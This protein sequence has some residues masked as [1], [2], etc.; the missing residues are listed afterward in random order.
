MA[1]SVLLWAAGSLTLWITSAFLACSLGVI[2]AAGS[3]YRFT[4]VV[5]SAAINVT[6][7]VPTSLLVVAIGMLCLRVPAIP[8]LPEI[9]PGTSQ[10]FQFCAWGITTA[11]ALGSSG[12]IAVIYLTAWNSVGSRLMDQARVLGLPIRVQASVIGREAA[13]LVV[14]ALGPRLVHH[15]HNTA[16]AALFPV[17]ELFGGVVETA[18]ET[19]QV[20]EAVAV[21]ALVYI[22]MSQAVWVGSRALEARLRPPRAR[23]ADRAALAEVRA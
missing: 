23:A 21:G 12:H 11:L 6:R 13:P 10:P 18:N 20:A 8:W 2:M 17:T 14:G 7:G 15:L 1:D 5:A 4:R 22:V 16:F 19:F 3:R 9:F